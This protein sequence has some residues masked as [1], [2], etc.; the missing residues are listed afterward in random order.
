LEQQGRKRQHFQQS[1]FFLMESTADRLD[2]FNTFTSTALNP[3]RKSFYRANSTSFCPPRS[4]ISTDPGL[5]KA[6][7]WIHLMCLHNE[8]QFPGMYFGIHLTLKGDP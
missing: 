4:V 5:G 3:I 6:G 2:L 8:S 7:V 1:T